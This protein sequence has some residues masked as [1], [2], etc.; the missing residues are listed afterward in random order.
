M[1]GDFIIPVSYDQWRSQGDDWATAQY[2]KICCPMIFENNGYC[3]YRKFREIY[4][5]RKFESD[6]WRLCDIITGDETWIYH[7]KIEFMTTRP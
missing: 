1:F 5:F 2:S 3:P 6:E 7:L 4:D